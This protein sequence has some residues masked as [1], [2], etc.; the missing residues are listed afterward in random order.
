VESL[1]PVDSDDPRYLF[2]PPVCMCVKEN[3]KRAAV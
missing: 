2:A 1:S 3:M